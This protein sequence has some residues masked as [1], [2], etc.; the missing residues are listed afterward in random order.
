MAE[1]YQTQLIPLGQ[2]GVDLKRE[3]DRVDPTRLT[4][5][6]NLRKLEDG[7]L[8]VRPGLSALVSGAG[9]LHS[10]ARLN[11]PRISTYERFWGLGTTVALGNAGALVVADTGYSGNPLSLLTYRPT[12]SSDPWLFI[13]DSAKMRQMSPAGSAWSIGLPAPVAACTTAAGS[14][15]TVAIETFN[16]FG[17]FTSHDSGGGTPVLNDDATGKVGHATKMTVTS[18]LVSWF[19]KALTLDLTTFGGGLASTDD[20]LIHFW[21]KVDRPD[22]LIEFKVY[23]VVSSF[24]TGYIPGTD[25]SHNTDAYMKA[26]TSSQFTTLVT[27]TQTA[28]SAGDSIENRQQLDDYLS[29]TGQSEERP[30]ATGARM[31][32]RATDGAATKQLAPGA[33]QWTEFGVVGVPVRKS[34]FLRIGTDTSKTWANVSGIIIEAKINYV[35]TP[36]NISLNNMFLRGG[37]G[38]DTAEVGSSQYDYRYTN[39]NLLTGDESNPSPVQDN[40]TAG[41]VFLDA[42]RQSLVATPAAYGNTNV[43]QRFYRRGGTLTQDWYFAGTNASDGTAF[44][45]SSS[46]LAIVDS[47]LLAINHDQPVTTINGSGATVLAQPLP[48]LW[49]PVQDLLFACGDP[50]RPGV[51]YWCLPGQPG[52][53]PADYYAEVCSPSEELMNGCLWSG[54]SYVFSRERLFQ[55]VPNLTGAGTVS[56]IPTTCQKGLLGRWSLAVGTGGIY[57]RAVD[58]IYVTQGGEAVSLTDDILRGLFHGETLRGYAPVDD[59]QLTVQRLAVWDNELYYLYQ[60][61]LGSRNVLVFNLLDKA[62]RIYQFG[63]VVSSVFAETTG[64]ANTLIVGGV[65]AGYVLD[66]AATTDIGLAIPWRAFTGSLDQ[67]APRN[68]KRYGDVILDM[69]RSGQLVTLTPWI[70]NET[71]ALAGLNITTGAG[72]T[73]YTLDP[74]GTVTTRARNVAFELT[75]TA[76]GPRLHFLGVSAFLLPDST[77]KRPTDWDNLGT[78]NSKF[79]QGVSF[80]ADTGNVPKT[81]LVE[82]T[83]ANGAIQTAASLT[84]QTDGVRQVT[85]TWPAVYADLI[86]LRAADATEWQLGPILGWKAELIP[87]GLYRWETQEIRHGLTNWHS[88]Y[89]MDV[90]LRSTAPVTVLLTAFDQLGHG[91]SLT[92]TLPSTAGQKSTL[93]LPLK[94]MKGIAWKYTFTSTAPFSLYRPETTAIVQPWSGAQ[95]LQLHPFGG[96]VLE[97]SGSRSTSRANVPYQYGGSSM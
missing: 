6:T 62:W 44:T 94:A 16:A 71:S 24:T 39:Y 47:G 25:A 70:N 75:G 86:R 50:Y 20:D 85:Y 91:T 73:R 18:S 23:L 37:E 74:F 88:V 57:F 15:H 42:L 78:Q 9:V 64:G 12:L 63:S 41:Q 54:Q 67:G 8:V 22:I 96:D 3:V 55:C 36:V 60:D 10:F 17:G 31:A 69:D 95:M 5:M 29:L 27:S 35:S 33:G 90:T 26:F 30:G 40:A 61:T 14:E 56:A 83:V 48:C 58:G 72:R 97:L 19:D 32:G 77:I 49:G 1:Q 81:V 38:P 92:Y 21:V 87:V 43:R 59:S 45:D 79:L 80:E 82:Y 34:D 89:S 53:W 11:Q 4:R 51:L 66:L 2:G 7:S 13:G 65:N 46:D 68:E 84:V 52:H 28:V 76:A 93:F